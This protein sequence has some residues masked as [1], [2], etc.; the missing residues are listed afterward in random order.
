MTE[1]EKKPAL[2][3]CG[4]SRNPH[5]LSS[6]LS[7]APSLRLCTFTCTI[8]PWSQ[9]YIMRSGPFSLSPGPACSSCCYHL[10]IT[11]RLSRSRPISVHI[12]SSCSLPA[13]AGAY[14][15]IHGLPSE[16]M[17]LI[18]FLSRCSRVSSRSNAWASTS[19][20]SSSTQICNISSLWRGFS[21]HKIV[22]RCRL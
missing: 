15:Q 5:S 1:K 17:F 3:L 19:D 11:Q 13:A 21:Y 14:G 12:V 8:R 16:T 9:H 4:R 18:S 6:S 22:E 10:G 7:T 2:V 20:L